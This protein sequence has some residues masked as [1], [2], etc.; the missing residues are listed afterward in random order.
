[1]A[2]IW[3]R[4]FAERATGT[5][6]ADI[7]SSD[8]YSYKGAIT[9]VSTGTVNKHF[10][11]PDIEDGPGLNMQSVNVP[12]TISSFGSYGGVRLAGSEIQTVNGTFT[13]ALFAEN[14][15]W[16]LRHALVSYKL[17]NGATFYGNDTFSFAVARSFLDA[18]NYPQHEL[19]RGCKF[20]DVS[21]SC[22]D[23]APVL[24]AGFGIVGSTKEYLAGGTTDPYTGN[25]LLYSPEPTACDQYPSD[26]FTFQDM[27]LKLGASGTT[28]DIQVTEVRNLSLNFRNVLDPIFGQSRSV[29]TLQRTMCELSWSAEFTMT[30][31]GDNATT[32]LKPPDATNMAPSQY[33]RYKLESLK[34]GTAAAQF[35]IEFKFLSNNT[36]KILDIK[37]GRSLITQ[38]GD[39]MPIARTFTARVG[40]VAMLGSDCN[41]FTIDFPTL[42]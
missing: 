29:Q 39:V 35:P 18:D 28:A 26:I 38:V 15:E 10:I 14:A 33:L 13:T 31:L 22:S 41:N 17:R 4:M 25:A 16:L 37:V 32:T 1:M 36:G 19:Y 34:D 20:S 3:G 24:R 40:G 27:Q 5:A 8:K 21:L 12:W 6:A 23:Q 7:W 11:L 30:I 9:G 2:R 42:S